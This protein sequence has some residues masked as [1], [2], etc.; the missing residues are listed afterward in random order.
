MKPHFVFK[1]VSLLL[2]SIVNFSCAYKLS[3]AVDG[4]PGGI[5]TITVPL[6]KNESKEPNIE[7][8]FTNSFRSEVLRFGRINLVNN[9]SLAEAVVTG[10]IKSVKIVSDESVIESRNATYLPY[11]TVLATQV[12]VAVVVAMKM[13]E[14]KTQKVLWS[15]DYE[16]SKNYTPPQI[17]LPVINSANNLYNLSE[18]RQ[19]LE[20][21]SKDMMQLALDRLVDNF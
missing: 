13:T 1:F 14:I 21:I 12:K 2:C 7:V 8:Y 3:N 5:K 17:T 11:G 18:R 20:T 6:F 9:E 15:G 10:T 4:L 16:Q 19:T